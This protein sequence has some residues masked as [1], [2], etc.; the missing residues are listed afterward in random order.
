MTLAE[1]FE[2]HR[3]KGSFVLGDRVE[4]KYE[5]IPFVGSTGFE[6]MRSE[7]EG[8]MVCVMLD[9]PIKLDGKTINIIRVKGNTLKRRKST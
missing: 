1:Y 7:D 6:S 3:P 4:G 9:L 2:L 8:L 5:G